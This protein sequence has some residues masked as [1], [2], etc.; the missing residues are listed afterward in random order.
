M[1]LKSRSQV[2]KELAELINKCE[3][4]NKLTVDMVKEWV[5]NEK[6]A[7]MAALHEFQDKFM[8]YFK[9]TD[10]DLNEVLQASTDAWNYF[11]HKTLG[12]KSPHD[13]VN[14]H[15]RKSTA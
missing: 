2:E 9:N 11:P 12:G 7:P 15:K 10:I 3:L 13:I 5:L 8:D 1:D 4:D 14:E 6:G